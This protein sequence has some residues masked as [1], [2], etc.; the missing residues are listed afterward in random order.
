[1][2][3]RDLRDQTP[4]HLLGEWRHFI[5]GAKS[6]FDVTDRDPAIET[7]EC[8]GEG[9]R[10]VALHQDQVWRFSDEDLVELRYHARTDVIW[11]LI[12]S[13]D[14][15]IVIDTD[16]EGS[17]KGSQKGRVLARTHYYR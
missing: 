8:S 4:A 2:I 13:H 7:R 9:R 11:G 6:R 3:A 1:M 15:E 12:L 16:I 17:Q 5:A 10:G 14:P